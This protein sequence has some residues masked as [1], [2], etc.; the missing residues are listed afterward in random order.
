MPIGGSFVGENTKFRGRVPILGP[1]AAP[2]H[3]GRYG[4]KL[5]AKHPDWRAEVVGDKIYLVAMMVL[6]EIGNDTEWRK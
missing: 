3:G 6:R 2:I 5:K 4:K 1:D